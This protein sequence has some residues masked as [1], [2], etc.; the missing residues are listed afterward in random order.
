MVCK[1]SIEFRQG[2]VKWKSTDPK[3]IEK[4]VTN[5]FNKIV[6]NE[7]NQFDG[8][9]IAGWGIINGQF[10]AGVRPLMSRALDIP[11]KEVMDFIETDITV[12]MRQYHTRMANAIEITRQFG[13]RHMD[14]F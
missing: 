4:R 14:N 6:D 7:A 3:E 5:T 8:D 2:N 13:D 9:G 10:K 12:L 1:K 11:N